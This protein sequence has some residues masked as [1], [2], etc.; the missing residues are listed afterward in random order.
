MTTQQL[1]VGRTVHYTLT[2][3]DAEAINRRRA[4]TGRHLD[5]HRERA[6]GSQL[7]VG[8][9]ATTGDVYPMLIVRVWGGPD[10]GVNGQVLLDGNDTYWAT[11][12][13]QA[14]GPEGA[15]GCWHWPPWA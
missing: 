9:H 5:E 3:Q 13:Q 11:S 1:T 12:R 7:H 6:D 14:D 4:D 15:P 2:E 10:T 8:N